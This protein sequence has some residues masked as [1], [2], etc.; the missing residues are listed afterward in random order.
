MDALVGLL[1]Y[2]LA[3]TK[4]KGFEFKDL[5][6]VINDFEESFGA[7]LNR[8]V[9]QLDEKDTEHAFVKLLDLT[10][11]E[12]QQSQK[13]PFKKILEEN[14][15]D[16]APFQ[17]LLSRLEIHNQF[18]ELELWMPISD[19]S[20]YQIS[21]AK[22]DEKLRISNGNAFFCYKSQEKPTLGNMIKIR[23]LGSGH[24]EIGS[25]HV[26]VGTKKY[27]IKGD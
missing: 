27:L 11:N 7:N 15:L 4:A 10:C 21:Q 16:C 6:P 24:V 25:G 13:N 20:H 17:A 18:E 9:Y 1:D 19:S 23:Y 12:N 5:I 22:I 14:E 3:K 2:F 26:E 8:D